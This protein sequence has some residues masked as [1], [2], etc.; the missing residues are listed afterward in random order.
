M[1]RNS[2]TFR[3]SC[4]PHK[5]GLTD[6]Y[7]Q[8]LRFTPSAASGL[9]EFKVTVASGDATLFLDAVSIVPR[10]ANEI[11]V[12][13]SSFEGTAM[14]ATWP[15]YLQGDRVAGWVCAG[16][17]YGVNAYSPKTFFVE[18]FL[19]NGINS[20]Q[21]NAW[22][23]QGAV[24]MKQIVTGLSAGQS[25]TLVFDYNFRDG[26][27]QD[28]SVTP[29]IGQIDISLDGTVI[30]TSDELPPVDTVTPWPGFRHTK[31]F[32]QMFLPITPA[33]ETVELQLAHVNIVG[34]ETMLVDN[35]RILPGTRTPPQI[36]KQLAEQ[37]V[38]AGATVTFNVGASGT[39]LSY[40]WF[41]DGVPLSDGGAISGAT[42]ATLTLNNAQTTDSGTY[43]AIA[44]DGVGV[45]G[46]AALL[47]VEG[48]PVGDVSLTAS[49]TAGQLVIAWPVAATGYVLQSS[50]KVNTGWADDGA[51]AVQQ[52]EQWVVSVTTGPGSKFYRLIKR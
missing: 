6:F 13:N 46:S 45:V 8:E 24:S 10:I 7:F 41:L 31:P 49:L 44:S 32:Y 1:A 2:L 40:R 28:S 3:V 52:G 47:T 23:G 18:P 30:K 50:G 12:M 51:A 20:D 29:N 35:V 22:F 42:T 34:D 16:G 21:D 36:T 9:L 11:A 17:N 26:R 27:A 15:G 37:T 19:D 33:A 38:A 4:L 14:G 5:N 48:A 39:G 43:S 25:Y